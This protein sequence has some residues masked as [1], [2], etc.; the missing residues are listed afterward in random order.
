MD[1]DEA[2]LAQL[3]SL[4]R[5]TD[6]PPAL[7]QEAARAAYTWRTVDRELAELVFDSAE[8]ALTGIRAEGGP[9]LLT[10]AAT[11]TEVEVQ[12]SE[13]PGGRRLVGQVVPPQQGRIDVRHRDGVAHAVA[14]T[15]GRFSA[16]G[17]PAG[18]VSLRCVLG[19]AEDAR[20][21]DTD[22]LTV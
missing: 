16:D 12:V 11:A 1:R 4:A 20:V 6:P 8:E 10:F 3:R 15:L 7:L 2:L 17:I 13:T 9:R 18:P 21:V 5:E 14:D 19:E 22:W